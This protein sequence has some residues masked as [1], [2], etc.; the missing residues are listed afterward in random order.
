MFLLYLWSNYHQTWHDGTL[1]L[2]L[3]RI[4]KFDDSSLSRLYDVIKQF[5]VSFEVEIRA[6]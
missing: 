4:E 1:E 6:P 3:K 2:N 5:S